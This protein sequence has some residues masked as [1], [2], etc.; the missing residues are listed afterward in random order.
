MIFEEEEFALDL[1]EF[2]FQL[3]ESVGRR[4]L[5]VNA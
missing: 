3:V 4:C 5:L 2:E 1:G